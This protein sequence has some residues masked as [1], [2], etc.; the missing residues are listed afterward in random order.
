MAIRDDKLKN[1]LLSCAVRHFAEKGYAATNLTEIAEETG[2][3]R[4]PLYYYF[5]DKAGL[6]RACVHCV[7]EQKKEAYS[8]ILVEEKPILDVLREDLSFC[9]TDGGLLGQVGSGGKDEPDMTNERL[10]FSHWLFERKYQVFSAA[11]ERGEL[12][13]SCDLSQL[14]TF[15]YIYYHGVIQVKNLYADYKGCSREMLD[16]SADVFIDLVRRKF[17]NPEPA[18]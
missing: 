14:I 16:H 18:K 11:K 9:L 12:P 15:L 3:T 1:K 4:G 10:A 5:T 2:V 8:H 7:I 13:P 6:Y 17:L